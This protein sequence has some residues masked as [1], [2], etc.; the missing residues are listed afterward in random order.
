MKSFSELKKRQKQREKEKKAAEKAAK[1][2]ADAAAKAS[3]NEG[4]PKKANLAAAFDE[5][6]KDPSK[7]TENRKNFV[8]NVRD[9]G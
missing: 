4:K 2:A 1:K 9:S 6:E 5:E 8:K 3:A 7:Y